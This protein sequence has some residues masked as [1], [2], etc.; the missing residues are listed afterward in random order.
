M[1]EDEF[2]EKKFR[3]LLDLYT[4]MFQLEIINYNEDFNHNLNLSS[5]YFNTNKA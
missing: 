3:M 4:V 2:K 1:S 5:M